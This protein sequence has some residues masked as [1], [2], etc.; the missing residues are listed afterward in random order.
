MDDNASTKILKCAFP[1]VW[2]QR[3]VVTLPI[4][5][6]WASVPIAYK[7][8]GKDF[9]KCLKEDI[10]Q[11]G[12]HFPLLVVEATFSQLQAQK[13]K[14]KQS[15]LELP[16]GYQPNQK[17]YVIWGG[18]NRVAAA[19]ELG[20]THIDCVLYPDGAF[21]AAWRDQGI[22]RDPF[23]HLYTNAPLRSFERQHQQQVMKKNV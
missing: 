11:K 9:F 8:R 15:I 23:K 4:N 12:M 17:I 22:Q 20:Y 16:T 19:K 1:S 2:N 13:K 10:E 18:S 3:P 6:L 21:D 7:L 14:Y 5:D